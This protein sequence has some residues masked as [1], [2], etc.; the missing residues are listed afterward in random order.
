MV[1]YLFIYLFCI[2]CMY[3]S[4]A[5]LVSDLLSKSEKQ[6][7]YGFPSSFFASLFSPLGK[8]GSF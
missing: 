8:R 2:V 4:I 7:F 5:S 3:F 1:S 6:L